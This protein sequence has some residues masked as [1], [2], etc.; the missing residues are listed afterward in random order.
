MASRWQWIQLGQVNSLTK[1]LY[2]EPQLP[3][4]LRISSIFDFWFSK[5]Y[6]F[7]L[8]NWSTV[9]LIIR[10]PCCLWWEKQGWVHSWFIALA[11]TNINI[12]VILHHFAKDI[13]NQILLSNKLSIKLHEKHFI[14]MWLKARIKSLLFE[15]PS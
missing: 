15:E 2:P 12:Y 9:G 14:L 1:S 7:P 3:N 4:L 5:Q 6:W 13:R 11:K 10:L 8:T